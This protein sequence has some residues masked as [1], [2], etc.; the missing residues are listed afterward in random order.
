MNM[1]ACSVSSACSWW[2]AHNWYNLRS[3]LLHFINE[4]SIKP[5]IILHNF[6]QIFS[7]Y[8]SM[9][10]IGVLCCWVIAPDEN[11]VDIFNCSSCFIS[12]DAVST[13]LIQSCKRREILL[14]NWWCKVRTNQCI[15]I[16]RVA[17]DKNF[18]SFFSKLINRLSLGLEDFCVCRKKI[19]TLHSWST[20]SCSNKN[21]NISI[22]KTYVR[23]S[24][25]NNLMD[26]SV[27]SILQVHNETLKYFFSNW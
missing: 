25:S 8:S 1:I 4:S 6:A 24:S 9:E 18:Y 19:W 23:I 22:C 11:I 14:W 10:C 27:S 20:W 15:G 17:D 21:T 2:L 12:D 26:Q 7:F 13:I 5:S 16:G 3:T